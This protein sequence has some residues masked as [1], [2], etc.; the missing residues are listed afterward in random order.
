M[1]EDN[2]VMSSEI[3][4]KWLQSRNIY[5]AKLSFKGEDKI[6]MFSGVDVLKDCT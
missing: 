6:K 2:G 3:Q 4:E 5:S 1:R